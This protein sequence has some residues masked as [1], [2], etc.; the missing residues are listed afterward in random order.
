LDTE[1]PSKVF[2]LKN[3]SKSCDDYG[4]S[5]LIVVALVMVV[6]IMG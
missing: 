1:Y 3:T 4:G 5:A 6:V 2:S